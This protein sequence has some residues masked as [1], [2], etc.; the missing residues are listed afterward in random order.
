M[1][2]VKIIQGIHEGNRHGA[3]WKLFEAPGGPSARTTEYTVPFGYTFKEPPAV[4]V[5]IMGMEILKEGNHRYNVE[6]LKVNT[7][8]FVIRYKTWG[9]TQVWFIKSAWLAIGQE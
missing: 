8:G 2:H 4:H 9:D 6:V 7:D 1:S 3:E 5:S